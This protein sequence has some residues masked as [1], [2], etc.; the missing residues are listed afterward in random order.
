M[1][2]GNIFFLMRHNSTSTYFLWNTKKKNG[3]MLTKVVTLKF[4]FSSQVQNRIDQ[5][6]HI[7]SI[8]R[9]ITSFWMEISFIQFL[10]HYHLFKENSRIHH[11]FNKI[12]K[13]STLHGS[14]FTDW[15]WL[16]LGHLNKV[17]KSSCVNLHSWMILVLEE[18]H[19]FHFKFVFNQGEWDSK[20]QE[21]RSSN[22]SK[23]IKCLEI[24]DKRYFFKSS[25]EKSIGWCLVN[26][27]VALLEAW[28]VCM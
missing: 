12:K 5:M 17:K 1:Y 28:S 15:D 26:S 14:I 13:F 19:K 18:Y 21:Q 4:L 7:S 16:V 2:V 8:T 24:K 22:V 3:K 25:Q 20:R 6:I 27:A 9:S 23:T 10:R 11:S